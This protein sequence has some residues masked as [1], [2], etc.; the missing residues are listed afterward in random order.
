MTDADETVVVLP[1]DT[2]PDVIARLDKAAQ[3]GARVRLVV[4]IDSPLLL[5]A[6][7]FRALKD[8]SD[9]QRFPLAIRTADPLRL[10]LAE[11][12]GL[13]TEALPRA[14]PVAAP[15]AATASLTAPAARSPDIASDWP[16]PPPVIEQP[17]SADATAEWPAQPGVAI[18]E[19]E[20][21]IESGEAEHEIDRERN[22]PRRWLPIAAGLV[23]LVAAAYFGVR[24]LVPSA[25]LR[26][27]P[28]TAAAAE[29]IVFDITDDGRTL[30]EAAAFAIHPQSQ[31]VEVVW[32]GSVPTTGVR[33][34][35]DGSAEGPVEL[36]NPSP[37]PVTVAGGTVVTTE[38]GV[39]FAFAED[40]SIPGADPATGRP[41]AVS[42]FVRAVD[43]GS[44]GNIE[45]G[46]LG[47]RLPNG[48]YY[49]NRM[50]P[51]TG[52]T[53]KE[54]PVVAEADLAALSSAAIEAAPEL[55]MS[56]LSKTEADARVLRTSLRVADQKDEFDAT[57]G[58]NAA[59][60][61]VRSTLTLELLTYDGAEARAKYE[62]L[63]LEQL[64]RAVPDG[65]EIDPPTVWYGE[66]VEINDDQGQARL[67]VEAGAN[68]VA[69]LD[70]A[71]RRRLAAELAG[72][73]P[74]RA[75]EM[76]EATSEIESFTVD[77]QPSWLTDQMPTNPER[78]IFEVAT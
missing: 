6:V 28:K 15:A 43:A 67:R 3:Q 52:G 69:V 42:T 20:E 25:V 58:A 77:Y 45:T 14:R 49:S 2:L 62:P 36:R 23:V 39:A 40:V 57:V 37:D 75:I 19:S 64:R 61:S 11:R 65:Y 41:G 8:A 38:T 68:A 73:E 60:V 27:V 56:E 78:I 13:S 47:G 12:T 66:P 51:T 54:F 18:L 46:Q 30:D 72:Q 5:T 24:Y 29:S 53:D 7:E 21:E 32:E 50:S 16:G 22:P 44:G 33:V 9:E 55:A 59:A 26:I 1:D 4:P 71:E 70:E 34:E 76:L 35:P 74:D 31:Q 63:L 17:P 10:Q 48:V